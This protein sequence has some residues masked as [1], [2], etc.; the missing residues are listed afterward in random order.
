MNAKDKLHTRDN[1]FVSGV[2]P[3]KHYR[4]V[5]ARNSA[6][7]REAADRHKAS[8]QIASIMGETMLGAFFLSTHATKQIDTTVSLHLECDAPI[9]RIIS[10]ADNSGDMRSYPGKPDSEFDDHEPL[11]SGI[12]RVNRW[13]REATKIYSSAVEMRKVPIYKNLE[14]FIGKS[15]Q[16]QS[17]IKIDSEKDENGDLQISGYMFQALP[18]ASAD[19]TD[20]ILDMLNNVSAKFVLDGIL[21]GTEDRKLPPESS[22]IFLEAKILR[23]GY[24]EFRCDCNRSKIAGLIRAMKREEVESILGEHGKIEAACEFCK[25]KY[26][27]TAEEATSLIN[28]ED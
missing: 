12:M 8:Q 9:Y 15:E 4:F 24:F 11:F 13:V 1:F 28:G 16:I 2:I 19:D 25:T 23:T 17:F 27:F 6:I 20:S 3:D 18:D 26:V 5:I 10:F 7:A 22:N 21:S 14:E